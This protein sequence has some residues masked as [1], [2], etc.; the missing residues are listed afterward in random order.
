MIIMNSK[1]IKPTR[2]LIIKNPK[3]QAIRDNFRTIIQ[4]AVKDEWRRLMDL[5]GLYLEKVRIDKKELTSHHK[6]SCQLH[7]MKEYL[8]TT[9][10][11]SICIDYAGGSS[12]STSIEGDRVRYTSISQF[13]KSYGRDYGEEDDRYKIQEIWFSLESYERRREFLEKYQKRMKK[14]LKQFPGR[15]TT[16]SESHERRLHEIRHETREYLE[17][18]LKIK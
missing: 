7:A 12:L 17:G 13:E 10:S 18:I 15:I 5:E 8:I 11:E 6:R 4:L 14:D 2:K 1:K 16:P 3:L 9:L